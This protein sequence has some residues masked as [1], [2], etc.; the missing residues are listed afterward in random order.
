MGN[1]FLK[2][3]L[4]R[5]LAVPT[6]AKLLTKDE[7]RRIAANIA[8][9]PEL[10]QPGWRSM[11]IAPLFPS[12]RVWSGRRLIEIIPNAEPTNSADGVQTLLKGHKAAIRRSTGT[13]SVLRAPRIV[14]CFSRLFDAENG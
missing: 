5:L 11:R 4:A 7:A 13:A 10:L 3:R 14:L 6:A 1:D 8:K 2:E 9:L 12:I